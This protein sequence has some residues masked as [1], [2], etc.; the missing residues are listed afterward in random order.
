MKITAWTILFILLTSTPAMARLGESYHKCRLR[1]GNPVRGPVEKD[2]TRRAH[3][4]WQV[5]NVKIIF[6]NNKAI[7]I[8]YKMQD[9]GHI[10][11]HRIEYIL[12]KNPSMLETGYNISGIN[13][14]YITSMNPE[15]DRIIFSQKDELASGYY[16][17]EDKELV[18][19]LTK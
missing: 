13:A 16:N 5:Y 15:K 12:S 14:W 8:H 3:Y 2:D 6:S 10:S 18:L 11:M 4:N 19:K 1:Y 7:R 17:T 9:G